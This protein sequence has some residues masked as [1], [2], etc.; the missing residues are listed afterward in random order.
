[1]KRNWNDYKELDNKSFWS[2]FC[3]LFFVVVAIVAY[4]VGIALGAHSLHILFWYFIAAA[5]FQFGRFVYFVSRKGKFLTW[6][7]R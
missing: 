5:I 3:A 1:M 2:F 6:K 4:Y 7:K